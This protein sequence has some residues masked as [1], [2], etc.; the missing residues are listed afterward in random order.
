MDYSIES[1]A[2]SPKSNT[3][4]T[5]LP[6]SEPVQSS[7][8][9]STPSSCKNLNLI[10]RKKKDQKIVKGPQPACSDY[11]YSFDSEAYFDKNADDKIKSIGESAVCNTNTVPFI[12][13]KVIFYDPN[14]YHY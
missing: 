6:P 9:P 7:I 14:C 8:S 12:A 4:K 5:T 13:I 11:F 1:P 10:S 2:L 3:P